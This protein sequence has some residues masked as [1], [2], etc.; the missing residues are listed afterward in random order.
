[1]VCR[2]NQP[3]KSTDGKEQDQE[4]EQEQEQEEQQQEEQEATAMFHS[5]NCQRVRGSWQFNVEAL[6]S[7]HESLEIAF[8]WPEMVEIH[9]HSGTD[10]SNI[11][12]SRIVFMGNGHKRFEIGRKWRGIVE[13]SLK[14]P[15]VG[16]TV[17][18]N[19]EKTGRIGKKGPNFGGKLVV[20]LEIGRRLSTGSSLLQIDGEVVKI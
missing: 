16:L 13:K 6:K 7:S 1:M 19:V 11:V 17:M 4:Q 15:S 10:S 5:D 12:E 9:W 3:I 8:N 14:L 20:K 18:E 2:S